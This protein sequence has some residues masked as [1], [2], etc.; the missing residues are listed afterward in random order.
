MTIVKPPFILDFGKAR[1][2]FKPEYP[3]D[4]VDGVEPARCFLQ[5]DR[6]LRQLE[7]ERAEP[8]IANRR[9]QQGGEV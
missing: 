8:M 4:A 5:R 1:L 7:V 9:M 3:P 6:F 2:Y